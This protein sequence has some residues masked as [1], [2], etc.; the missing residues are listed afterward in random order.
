LQSVTR[1][2]FAP[3]WATVVGQAYR[4]S[5]SANAPDLAG[6]TLSFNYM[7]D[8]VPPGEEDWLVVYYLAPGATAWQALPTTLDTYYNVASARTQGEGLYVLMSSFAI[9]LY[10][11]GWDLFAYPLQV[12]KTVTQTL[13]S[14]D[15]KYSIVYW[16]DG[17]DKLDPW[18]VYSVTALGW[19]NDLHE[20][21]FGEAYWISVTQV[22]TLQLGGG[23]ASALV[24]TANLQGPPATYYGQ[25]L[26][27]GGSFAPMEG[28]TVTA[29]INGV[30]CGQGRTLDMSGQVMY[31]LNVLAD[32]PGGVAGCGDLGRKVV[33]KVGDQVMSPE[34]AWDNNQVWQ[35]NL[36]PVYR[37]YLP[38]V[39]RQ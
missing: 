27:R 23:S 12:T 8:Q 38:V 7:C 29:W 6:T 25:V 26:A 39:L 17:S 35:V 14:I 22:I 34:V 36:A 30:Q 24:S 31:T 3:G 19:V 13:L 28:M 5:H 16:Y 1:V 37:V 15:G 33:F 32:G 2:P 9:P 18:K 10:G 11:P 4:L 21:K 20:M